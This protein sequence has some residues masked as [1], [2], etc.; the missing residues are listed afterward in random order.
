MTRYRKTFAAIAAIV[1][2]VAALAISL[3]LYAVQRDHGQTMHMI[4]DIDTPDRIDLDVTII[5]IDAVMQEMSVQV[6]PTPRGVLADESGRFRAD[7]VIE[8]YGLKSQPIQ[9][10]AGELLS[11]SELRIAM[12]GNGMITDYPFDRYTAD[13]DVLATSGAAVVPISINLYSLDTFFKVAPKVNAELRGDVVGS[14]VT[15]TR[16]TASR[17]FALFVMV[18]ML[19]LA[20]AAATAAFYVL[21][22]RRGLIWPANTLMAAVLFAMIPLRNA[23]PGG[24]P[25]GSVIDFGSFFIAETVVALSLICTVLIGYRH[26]IGNERAAAQSGTAL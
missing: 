11:A 24:P 14:V 7:T 20:L 17:T 15:V 21:S 12:G 5:Q 16:S 26:E 6:L 3:Q 1:V 19:G 18:L 9:A 23:V 10:K 8:L 4:G 13:I 22:G 2:V 25:I